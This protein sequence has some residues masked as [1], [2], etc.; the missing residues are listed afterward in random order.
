MGWAPRL[1]VI[2]WLQLSAFCVY[3]QA[4][5]KGK[6]ID[7]I[8]REPLALAFVTD[9]RTHKNTLTDPDGAFLLKDVRV[10]D[11]LVI[12]FIG[13]RN[14]RIS[15]DLSKKDLVVELEKGTVD[16]KEVVITNVDLAG[17]RDLDAVKGQNFLPLAPTFTSTGGLDF[18]FKNG[19]NGESTTAICITGL[20][21]KTT[22]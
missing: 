22:S 10:S 17:P 6:V 16:L 11:S 14:E 19:I 18:R 20:L 7:K 15:A 3:G 8:T 2:L 5:I 21:M 1:G 12:S 13:Y 4:V 9:T